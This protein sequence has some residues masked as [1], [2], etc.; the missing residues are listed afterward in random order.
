MTRSEYKAKSAT[1]QGRYNLHGELLSEIKT[2]M[3]GLMEIAPAANQEKVVALLDKAY[4]KLESEGNSTLFDFFAG[5]H[6]NVKEFAR[7][8]DRI[9]R[10]TL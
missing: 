7:N 4:S 8:L 5:D 2:K 6:I 3:D 9:N 10:G 1:A